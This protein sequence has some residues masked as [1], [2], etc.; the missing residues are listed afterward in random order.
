MGSVADA[1]SVATIASSQPLLQLLK[2]GQSLATLS[3]MVRFF[4]VGG[5]AV[6]EEDRWFKGFSQ[7][8]CLAAL[9]LGW[10]RSYF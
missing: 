10:L 6:G 7:V 9:S 2:Y 8:A 5:V 4:A 1:N 3:G